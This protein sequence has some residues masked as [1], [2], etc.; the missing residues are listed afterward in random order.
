M[1][2]MSVDPTSK[3]AIIEALS[4]SWPRVAV[5]PDRGSNRA[6]FTGPV[7]SGSIGSGM[8]G[9]ACGAVRGRM[10]GV[11]P[12]VGAQADT[13]RI[14][15]KADRLV[16]RK[17]K[18]TRNLVPGKRR[19]HRTSVVRGSGAADIARDDF[20]AVSS[21][22]DGVTGAEA[23]PVVRA[24]K[25]AP[26][27]HVTA[28][29]IGNLGDITERARLALASADLVLCEDTRVTGKLLHLFGMKRP[30]LAYHDHNGEVV[31]PRIIERLLAGE[32]IVLVSDA[33]TPCIA[34]PGFKLV[35]DA[36]AQGIGVFAIPGPSSVTAALS[37]AGLATDRF[38]FNGF[39]PAKSR[40]RRSVLQSLAPLE[41]TL[42]FLESPARISATLADCAD[43]LG[44]R[45]AA[46]CRELTKLHEE[47]RMASL[48]DLAA[49]LAGG[50]PVKGEI[51]LLVAAAAR[52]E[53]A[54]VTEAEIDAALLEALAENKPSRAAAL[55]AQKTGL[56]REL[57]YKRALTLKS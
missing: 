29:P 3:I 13:V 27:L 57:L 1:T 9:W 22:D 35:R 36:R 25:L 24:S 20:S 34:D 12:G 55:V 44:K 42:V 39:L 32:A 19:S 38:L 46:I 45:D 37:I 11:E 56:A 10:G 47:V 50:T 23:S 33:G 43:I 8:A 30:L 2:C 4:I 7:R 18:D 14:S 53:P 16:D 26:G 52:G 21:R 17:R 51:V 49:E 41:A 48:S 54:M 40:E 5:G 6:T 31:R 28:T 15:R